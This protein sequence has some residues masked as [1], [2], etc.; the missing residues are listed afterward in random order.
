MKRLR[1][2]GIEYRLYYL[3]TLIDPD[4]VQTDILR[5]LLLRPHDPVHEVVSILDFA[6]TDR[7]EDA[8]HAIMDGKLA[9][10]RAGE[11]KLYLL[12]A[13][14]KKERSINIPINERVLRG[15]N[16][17]F[18]E[19]LDTNLNLMRKLINST[20]FVVKTF[21]IGRLSQTKM[22]VMYIK[23]IADSAYVA[24][25]ERRLRDIDI[26]YVEMPGFIDELVRDQKYSLFPQLLVTER[27]DPARAY[28]MEGKA[29][30]AAAG[31]PDAIIMPVSFWSLFQSPDEYQNNWIFGTVMR[32]VRLCCFLIA[33]GLPGLYVAVSGYNPQLLPINFVNTLQSSLKYVTFPPVIEALA[34]MLLLEIVRE[35]TIRLA[36]PVGQTIGVVGGIVVGTVVVQSNLVSNTMVIVAPVREDGEQEEAVARH[37]HSERM[38]HGVLR[39][40]LSRVLN[41]VQPAAA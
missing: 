16:Q 11:D 14:L 3:N 25:L 41:D 30:V 38:H 27:P 10:H 29:V 20:D 33:I 31:S 13:D 36:S 2:E 17:A 19:N 8:V 32:T 23:S 15:A 9:L 26:D 22:A 4:A 34:M 28:L 12:G 6:E 1:I 39:G 7:L 35:A 5:P 24:E 37:V 40:G 18:I 21:M